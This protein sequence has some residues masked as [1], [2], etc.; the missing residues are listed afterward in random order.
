MKTIKKSKQVTKLDIHSRLVHQENNDIMYTVNKL[1]AS[2]YVCMY[3]WYCP[4]VALHMRECMCTLTRVGSHT[5]PLRAKCTHVPDTVNM[6][7]KHSTR[8]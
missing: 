1:W 7:V 8:M 3:I 5:V 6:C 2:V 4:D